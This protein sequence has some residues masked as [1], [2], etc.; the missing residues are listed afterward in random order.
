M[1]TIRAL[2]FTLFI[3]L[4]QSSSPE[5]HASHRVKKLIPTL[6]T[7]LPKK[8]QKNS[9]EVTLEQFK[10]AIVEYAHCSKK[11]L[12]FNPW[13]CDKNPC[14]ESFFTLTMPA[15]FTPFAQKVV[16]P[17]GSKVAFFGDLHGNIDSVVKILTFLKKNAYLDDNLKIIKK[18]F[19]MMFLGDYVDRGSHGVEV[20]YLLL[21]LKI[22]NPNNV[23]L[24][25]GNHEDR[26]LNTVYGFRNEL[27]SKY[28]LMQHDEIESV[29][30][31]YDF[32]PTVIFLGSGASNDFI[33][34]CHG[35]MEIGYCAKELLNM[36]YSIAYQALG[37]ISRIESVRELPGGLKQEVLKKIPQKEIANFMPTQPTQP[38]TLGFMWND[39]IEQSENYSSA[40]IDYSNGRGW[41]YGKQLTALLLAKN[42]SKNARIR[43]VFR[44]HQHHGGMLKLLQQEKGIVKLWNGMVHTFLTASLP[45][46]DFAHTSLGI[47]T[48]ADQY[49]N[50]SLEHSIL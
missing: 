5:V 21:S 44:A 29:F 3:T 38:V 25:R 50:W 30:R 32:M 26:L 22:A 41:I 45:N 19:Y 15:S 42:S 2:V 11:E 24:V 48:T 34:C 39:F 12:L 13:L 1:Y 6:L 7:S 10:Q 4:F 23:F 40:L 17:S 37:T 27:R 36:P 18:D 31:C 49:Q 14:N 35:G 8:S 9:S 28:P 46:V 16:V 20:M 33:Q 47:L 43:A